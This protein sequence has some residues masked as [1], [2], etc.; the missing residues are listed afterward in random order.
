MNETQILTSLGGIGLLELDRGDDVHSPPDAVLRLAAP[1]R[2][3][4]SPRRTL[5]LHSE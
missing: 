1:W 4:V 2:S 3:M 5:D